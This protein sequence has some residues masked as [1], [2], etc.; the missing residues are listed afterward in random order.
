METSLPE[1]PPRRRSWFFWF[2]IV[3]AAF[4]TLV[5]GSFY[6]LIRSIRGTTPTVSRGSTVTID[7]AHSYPEETLY[8]IGGPFLGFSRLT[9]RDLLLGIEDAREDSRIR[10][11]LLHVRATTLG[12]AQAAELREKLLEF[13]SSGKSLVAFIEYGSN[14]DYFLASSADAIYI[15]PRTVL[16]LRGLRAE[17]IFIRSALEKIGVQAEFER[18]GAYKDAPDT[19]LRDD[20]SPESRE[21]LQGL[22]GTIHD[23]LL[24]SLVEG[25]GMDRDRAS[26]LIARGPFTASEALES[27]L[28]DGLHYID[29]VRKLMAPEGR[30]LETLPIRDYQQATRMGPSFG[31]RG[32]ARVAVI[33]GIGAIVSGSST[34]DAVFGRVMGSDTIAEAFESAREDEDIDAVVFRIDSPGGS[35]VASDVIWREAMLTR[36]KKPVVVSMANVAASGGYWVATASD[37]IVAEPATITGSIGIFAG[38]FNLA[39]LFDKVGVST[40]GVETADNADFFSSTRSFTP[41]EREKLR[42]ILESGYQAFLERVAQSRNRTIEEVHEIAQGRVWSGRAAHELGLVDELGGLDRA[43]TLAKVRAGFDA[44]APVELRIYPEKKQF[45]EFFLT[46]F[47]GGADARAP[48]EL[49]DPRTLLARSPLLRLAGEGAGLALMPFRLRIH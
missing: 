11:L 2:V 17:A 43:L 7:L 19:F 48:L 40:D 22:V 14:L 34:E 5:A 46:N 28:V 31:G 10:K 47:I 3:S 29:E 8:D 35:D 45:F 27:D 6:L 41:E 13:K 39:G 25:R 12:W 32:D 9:F 36:E 33:Y 18:V 37:A 30:K 1:R 44:E 49:L 15:H 38:K 42:Q 4:M 16:D 21:A 26:S 24:T 20:L 23:V